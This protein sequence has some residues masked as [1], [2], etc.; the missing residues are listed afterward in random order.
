MMNMLK[1][2]G[3]RAVML[4]A[5][6]LPALTACMADDESLSLDGE[7]YGGSKNYPI[8][9]RNGK[10]VVAECGNWGQDLVD[11][12]QNMQNPNH[13]CAVQHN[14]AAMLARPSDVNVKPKLG[15]RNS[16]L[17]VESVRSTQSSRRS[18]GF[19]DL[20]FGE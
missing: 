19:F 8:T 17:D 9:V 18:G 1:K 20:F 12:S 5:I 3:I 13:G 15:P 2:P 7:Q 6:A 10:A 16:A 14:V 4:L 11:S